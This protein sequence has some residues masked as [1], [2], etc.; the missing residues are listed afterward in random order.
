MALVVDIDHFGPW[1]EPE[2]YTC[3]RIVPTTKPAFG[4]L[5]WRD[6]PT[7]DP[8]AGLE[9]VGDE[10]FADHNLPLGFGQLVGAPDTVSR[11]VV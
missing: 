9:A 3:V 8:A 5:T 2:G 1:L 7:D 4:Q 11:E 10:R 6:G